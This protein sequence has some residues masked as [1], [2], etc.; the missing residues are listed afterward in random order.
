MTSAM[1]QHCTAAGTK[2]NPDRSYFRQRGRAD[3][4]M[5]F[6]S[7]SPTLQNAWT[8]PDKLDNTREIK[9]LKSEGDV[10]PQKL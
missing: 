9:A 2:T 6:E 4:L 8:G 1:L 3:K 7:T 10:D 5:R